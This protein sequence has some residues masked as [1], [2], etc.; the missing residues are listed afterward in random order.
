M[1]H[2][3]MIANRSLTDFTRRGRRGEGRTTIR[4]REAHP[5]S[6]L[7]C[8]PYGGTLCPGGAR[9]PGAGRCGGGSVAT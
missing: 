2:R 4:A 9:R 5:Q 7:T 8:S 1:E 3:V 6:I